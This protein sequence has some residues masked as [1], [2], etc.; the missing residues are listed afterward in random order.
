MSFLG[1]L[2]LV[3]GV[4]PRFGKYEIVLSLGFGVAPRFGN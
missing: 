4:A 3:F 1:V 2:S